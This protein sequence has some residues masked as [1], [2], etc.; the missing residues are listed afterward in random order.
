LI[1]GANHGIGAATAMAL[2]A[3]A[4]EVV[5]SYLR[6]SDPGDRGGPELYRTARAQGA[7]KVLAA[8]K[9][10]GG[11]PYLSRLTSLTHGPQRTYSTALK[12]PS[13]QWTS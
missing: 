6:I 11:E 2:A 8:I 5:V 9:E 1:T 10:V 7:E 3:R 12:L 4:A 13:G